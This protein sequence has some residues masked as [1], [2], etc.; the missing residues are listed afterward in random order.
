MHCVLY[1]EHKLL[2]PVVRPLKHLMCTNT[3]YIKTKLKT[4]QETT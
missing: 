4:K 3:Y 2:T 1:E